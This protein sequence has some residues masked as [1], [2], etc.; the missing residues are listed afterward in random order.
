MTTKQPDFQPPPVLDLRRDGLSPISTV[1]TVHANYRGHAWIHA[2]EIELTELSGQRGS[3][4]LDVK[5]RGA[6]D[7]EHDTAVALRLGLTGVAFRMASGGQLWLDGHLAGNDL[8]MFR[9]PEP[10]WNQLEGAAKCTHMDCR[11]RNARHVIVS[12]GRYI[13]Q[14]NVELFER[15]RGLRVEIVTGAAR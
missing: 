5:L 8:T 11:S 9:V 15:L 1:I 6:A 10:G 4:V 13:P 12:E 2:E 14:P 3:W 7:V